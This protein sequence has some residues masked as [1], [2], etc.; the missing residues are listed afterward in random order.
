MAG[1]LILCPLVKTKGLW[2]YMAEAIK[3]DD[4][5]ESATWGGC[6]YESQQIKNAD[7]CNASYP[8]SEIEEAFIIEFFD[9]CD[10][11][12]IEEYSDL[13]TWMEWE[14]RGNWIWWD[15]IKDQEEL[16]LKRLNDRKKELLED[17]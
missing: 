10:A 12:D 7:K 14:D 5:K 2:G 1:V 8:I 3:S 9:G 11:S 17:Y 4:R 6:S 15:A 16:I 13:S